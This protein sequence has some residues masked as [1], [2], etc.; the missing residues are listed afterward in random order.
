[1]KPVEDTQ[2]SVQRSAV[3]FI[4]QLYG[5]RNERNPSYSLAAFSRDL[6][7]SASLLSRVMSGTRPISLKLAMQISTALDL[8]ESESKTLM[9]S[10][11]QSSSKRAKISKK[12]RA[13]LEKELSSTPSDRSGLFFTTVEIEQFKAMAS[14][15]HLAILN[16]CATEGFINDATWIAQKLGI[17]S[18]EARDAVERLIT[19]GLLK[20]TE[21]KVERT[22]KS[23]YIKTKKS[24]F[25][26]R[27]FHQQMIGKA[28][29]ELN[30][31]SE[32]AF[33]RRLINGITF[34][35]DDEHIELIKEKIDRLENEI[36]ALV[37]GE[38]RKSVY[39][40]NIQFFPLTK[41]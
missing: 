28:T 3:E 2:I 7:I 36:L 37:E 18:V 34:T 41:R 24:E 8:D 40:M 4:R 32:E 9:L 23:F 19:I 29:E 39:Q 1:M 10:V 14:W 35:C 30:D 27:K 20:E 31:A 38:K 6:G 17:S 33:Q 25:A 11:L 22:K 21:D 26:V 16:L 13:K 5:E 15:Y 12:V